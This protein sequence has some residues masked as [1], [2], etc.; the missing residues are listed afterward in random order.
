MLKGCYMLLILFLYLIILFLSISNITVTNVDKYNKFTD[1]YVEKYEAYKQS[2]KDIHWFN[3][4]VYDFPKNTTSDSI[5]IIPIFNQEYCTQHN[6][7]MDKYDENDP[8]QFDK[9]INMNGVEKICKKA[10]EFYYRQPFIKSYPDWLRN[11]LTGRALEFDCY[12]EDLKI[13]LEYQGPT[14]YEWPNYLQRNKESRSAFEKGLARDQVK[15]DL[16]KEYGITLIEI[17]YTVKNKDLPL[18]IFNYLDNL[19]SQQTG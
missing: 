9:G 8:F 16:C 7:L 3:R 19:P 17:P 1:E 18:Y 4:Q 2:H 5:K 10:L 15:R 11:P 14:H 6:I 12:N 13:A